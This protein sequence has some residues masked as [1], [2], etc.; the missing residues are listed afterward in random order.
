[1]PN[2]NPAFL[3]TFKVNAKDSAYQIWE[4][5]ALTVVL[6]TSKVLYQKLDCVHLD[7][8]KAGLFN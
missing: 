3:K 6:F 1:M 7:P 5:N 4:R 2:S 8:V